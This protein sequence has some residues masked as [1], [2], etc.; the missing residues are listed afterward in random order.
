MA[1]RVLSISADGWFLE[2]PGGLIVAVEAAGAEE[3]A[4]RIAASGAE[5]ALVS[6]P[7]ASG[8]LEAV[9][10]AGLAA[11][12][13][14]R[15]DGLM[16]GASPDRVSVW[17]LAPTAAA[18]QL[19]AKLRRSPGLVAAPVADART[20]ACP[21]D[22]ATGR[23]ASAGEVI[24]HQLAA[25]RRPLVVE[26]AGADPSRAL[27]TAADL[28]AAM[29]VV[30]ADHGGVDLAGDLIERERRRLEAAPA[31][32]IIVC[33]YNEERHIGECLRSLAALNYPR[34][35]VVVVDD[36][37]QDGT[38]QIARDHGARLVEL[39]HVG[40][41]AARNAGV[42][43]AEGEVVAFLDA[44]EQALPDWPARLWRGMDACSADAVT[45]PNLPFAGD[46]LQARAV[47]ALP[48]AA[49]P[50]V[51]P[52]GV[53]EHLTTCNLAARRDLL[54][55][56]PFDEQRAAGEDVAFTFA[57]QDAGARLFYLPTAAVFHHR[58]ATARGYLRQQVS[59]GEALTDELRE[60]FSE[61]PARHRLGRRVVFAGSDAAQLF[62]H[63]AHPTEPGLPLRVALGLLATALGLLPLARALER[64]RLWALSTGVALGAVF[65]WVAVG[66]RTF[67]QPRGVTG[68][69]QRVLTA[70]LWLLRPGARALGSMRR[71]RLR[72]RGAVRDPV[73]N[74]HR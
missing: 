33:A 34:Y 54:V 44:D 58:R 16:A 9:E 12:A 61:P 29:L 3:D 57:A 73:T 52:G 41:S 32:S 45:G 68:K 36:G 1:A 30:R 65:V 24:D 72:A 14:P 7:P 71:R 50:V 17:H 19:P 60:R 49:I 64:R 37:S 42:R 55:A 66:V 62:A 8:V 10:A 13:E 27:A 23:A 39:D 43:A 69:W 59:Y 40:I 35:E 47:S 38:P 48:G 46:G 51:G 20:G 67:A 74:P 15:S 2:P 4:E 21:G 70:A 25:R 5:A 31:L 63:T 6:W 22:L 11:V 26:P 56:V 28:G 18:A 53:A